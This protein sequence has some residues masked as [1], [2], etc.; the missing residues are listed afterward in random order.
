MLATNSAVNDKIAQ[1]RAG[2]GN[3]ITVSAAGMRG[4]G[5]IPLGGGQSG[6]GGPADAPGQSNGNDGQK[7]DSSQSTTGNTLTNDDLAKIKQVAHI[8]GANASLTKQVDSD[9]TSLS[10]LSFGRRPDSNNSDTDD[11]DGST[12]DR[13]MPIAVTGV[14][15]KSLLSQ[16][17]DNL[18]L[19]SGSDITLTGSDKVAII[20]D[21]LASK[22]NL[23]VGS[24]F[25]LYGQELTVK[26]IL[27]SGTTDSTDGSNGDSKPGRNLSVGSMV[28]V[29]LATLQELADSDDITSIAATVDDVD[30]TDAAVSAIESAIGTNSDGNN[31]AEVTSDKAAAETT[32][33]SLTNISKMSLL[34]V[35]ICAV[36][37][38]VIIFLTM[39]MVVRERRREIGIMKAIGAK[40]RVIVTQFVAE[41]LVITVIASLLG[42][43]IGIVGAAPLTQALTSSTTSE[44][45][46]RS[47]NGEQTNQT[48]SQP[49][50]QD[51]ERRQPAGPGRMMNQSLASAGQVVA[52]IDWR[53][54]A[55][56][57][58]GCLL[59]A[60]LG[61]AAASMMAMK[62]KPAEAV[63]AE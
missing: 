31:I 20:G 45:T 25:T 27:A 12:T 63:R 17:A 23:S 37:A 43:G 1:I 51:D 34:S 29:P 2:I 56:A 33:S 49:V 44:Q 18:T 41:S 42:L 4:M 11:T 36:V 24:T 10:G 7:A 53:L 48:K 35:V 21:Q 52:K 3:N 57:I 62:V 28:I 14:T 8:T 26:G 39:L 22:N 5:G 38:A 50:S 30:N 13:T 6:Q 15:S 55:Y 60:G 59:I 61:A 46:A 19:S 16:T 32:I 54:V 58:L 9:Q 40:S 47:D